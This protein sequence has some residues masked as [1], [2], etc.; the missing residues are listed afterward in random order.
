MLLQVP[1]EV[2]KEIDHKRRQFMW[3]GNENLTRRKCKVYW[4]RTCMPKDYGSL[5]ILN[6]E[7]FSRALQLRWLCHFAA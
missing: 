7:K 3:A 2:I 6:I 1:K 4:E 5:G